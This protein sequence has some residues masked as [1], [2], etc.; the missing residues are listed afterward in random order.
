MSGTTSP[1]SIKPAYDTPE[2][3]LIF[4]QSQ[5]KQLAV[6]PE[7]PNSTE[8]MQ[9][10]R[11]TPINTTD[12]EDDVVTKIMNLLKENKEDQAA[13]LLFAAMSRWPVGEQINALQERNFSHFSTK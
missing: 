8:L 11:V 12:T 2:K 3:E 1:I 6:V 9:S 13:V 4:A 10:R 5:H 7:R